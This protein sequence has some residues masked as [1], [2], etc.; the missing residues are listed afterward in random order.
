MSRPAFRHARWLAAFCGAALLAPAASGGPNDAT[1]STNTLT[2]YTLRLQSSVLD[3]A[4]GESSVTDHRFAAKVYEYAG[5]DQERRCVAVVLGDLAKS[6]DIP[7]GAVDLEE[8]ATVELE[9]PVGRVLSRGVVPILDP[10]VPRDR[11]SRLESGAE[12][13]DLPQLMLSQVPVTYETKRR[14][15][16]SP[17]IDYWVRLEG[18]SFKHRV[19]TIDTTLN[20]LEREF[21]FDAEGTRVV[22][23]HATHAYDRTVGSSKVQTQE[24]FTLEAEE[25]ARRALTDQEV[26]RVREEYEYLTPV[27]D[28]LLPGATHDLRRSKEARKVEERLKGYPKRFRE[29]VLAEALPELE[30]GFQ[31]V[32]DRLALPE[33]PEEV[34][35]LMVGKPAPDFELKQLD[36][37]PF[38]LAEL[39]G[40]AVLLNFWALL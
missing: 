37:T 33:D 6:G 3:A 30:R 40:K 7:I 10:A 24:R 18:S 36:G 20:E 38:R 39:K 32:L 16:E 22:R 2:E 26:A 8:P 11:I 12:A 15:G 19:G 9:H 14:E 29:G 13:L 1:P 31:A 35:K 4:S 34:A 28:A 25:T 17:G 23:L 5:K 21:R 27:L